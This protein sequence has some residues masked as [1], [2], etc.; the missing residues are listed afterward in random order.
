MIRTAKKWIGYLEHQSNELLGIYSAN[1]GKG[2][3]T[4]FPE[5]IGKHYRRRNFTGLPWCVVFVHAVCI[6]AYGKEKARALLG[7]PQAGSRSL[8]RRMKRKGWLRGKDYIPKANDL[9]FLHNGSGEISHVG[10]VENVE[11]DT[12]ITIEGN[13]VDPSGHFPEKQGGAVARRSRKLT[14]EKIIC[15]AETLQKGT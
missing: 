12:V 10:I 6:E 1:V 3:C 4:I 2:G 5:I 14:D 13:T 7:K 8:A 15:Y 9:I 11:G